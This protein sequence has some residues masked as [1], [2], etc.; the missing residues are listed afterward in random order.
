MENSDKLC[1]VCGN[2]NEHKALVCIHCGAA[3][4]ENYPGPTITGLSPEASV[5]GSAVDAGVSIDDE[6]IPAD[7]IAI[8]IAGIDN[9]VYASIENEM[10]LGRKVQE[11]N[12]ALLDLSNLGGFQMGISRRHAIIRRAG[13]GYELIDLSSTNGTWVNNERL[14]PNKPYPLAIKSQVRL[15]RMR[16]IIIHRPANE[17]NTI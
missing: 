10:V 6:R 16:M 9:P 4:E 1:P 2:K 8:Y 5:D 13:T 14:I 12:E 15:G 11:T 7:G 17:G 3:L